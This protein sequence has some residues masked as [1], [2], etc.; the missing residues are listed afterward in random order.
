MKYAEGS[1]KVTEYRRQIASIRQQMRETQA[2]V[3][4]QD[5]EDYEFQTTRGPVRLSRE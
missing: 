3:E 5:V 2:A 4:P 1:A